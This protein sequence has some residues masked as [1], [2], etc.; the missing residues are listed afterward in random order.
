MLTNAITAEQLEKILEQGI[1][2]GKQDFLR[3]IAASS[4]I[5]PVNA[6]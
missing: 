4:D 2:Q 3:K 5:P 1:E 6:T